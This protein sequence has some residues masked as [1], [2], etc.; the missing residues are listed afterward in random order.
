MFNRQ[1]MRLLVDALFD[2]IN[3]GLSAQTPAGFAHGSF[4]AYY[5][6]QRWTRIIV[7]L[8]TIQAYSSGQSS[9]GNSLGVVCEMR[10]IDEPLQRVSNFQTNATAQFL[11]HRRVFQS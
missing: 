10:W 4:L 2:G 3:D 6:D 1:I 11:V 9:Y 7:G 8:Q 5:T